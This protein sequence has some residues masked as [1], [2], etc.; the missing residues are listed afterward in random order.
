MYAAGRAGT[1]VT[2]SA[3]RA[4]G[5]ARSL[6]RADHNVHVRQWVEGLHVVGGRNDPCWPQ[7]LGCPLSAQIRSLVN[8]YAKSRLPVPNLCGYDLHAGLIVQAPLAA[9][10]RAST[11]HPVSR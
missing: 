2:R 4:G 10:R 1:P 5:D 3:S 7:I 11:V 9:A 8:V 6:A